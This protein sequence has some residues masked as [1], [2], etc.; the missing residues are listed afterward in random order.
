[1]VEHEVVAQKN[2]QIM[3]GNNY[4]TLLVSVNFVVVAVVFLFA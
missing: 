2:E 3:S 4:K 1:M